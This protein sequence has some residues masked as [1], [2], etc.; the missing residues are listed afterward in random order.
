MPFEELKERQRAM[1]GAGP[2]ERVEPNLGEMHRATVAR[3]DPRPGERVLDVGC[4][5]G[6]V[7]FLAAE[8]GAE[9]TGLDLSPVLI[10]TARERAAER[11][12]SLRLEDGDAESL[13]YA[14]ASFD[15]VCSTVGVMFAPNQEAA[16]EELA[17]VCRPGGRLGV[18]SWS[19]DGTGKGLFEVLAPFQPPPAPGPASPFEWGR[20][21]GAERLLGAAFE[22]EYEQLDAPLTGPSAE[23]VW[24]TFS[25]SFGPITTLAGSL[26]PERREE[27]HRTFVTWLDEYRVD[28]GIHQPRSYLLA[29]G[30]RR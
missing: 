19:H 2:F 27:L 14:D 12:L 8:V 13:S 30:T 9:V 21:E 28:G 5:T 25:T 15:V 10:E 16:A 3:L 20:V 24:E 1:W 22:L 11:G 7:A 23:A 26:E 6:G 18:A 29:H 4:G 17:R